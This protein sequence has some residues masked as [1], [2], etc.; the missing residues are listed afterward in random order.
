MAIRRAG[1]ALLVLACACTS[2][3]SQLRDG[4]IASQVVIVDAATVQQQLTAK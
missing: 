2:G 4:K 1:L 3:P